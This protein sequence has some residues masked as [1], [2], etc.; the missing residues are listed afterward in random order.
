MPH[1]APEPNLHTPLT[2]QVPGIN[3][4]VYSTDGEAVATGDVRMNVSVHRG[5]AVVMERNLGSESDKVRP[6]ERIRGLEFSGDGRLLFVAAADT[7]YALDAATGATVWSYEP[8]RSFGFLIISPIALTAMGGLV[9]ASFDNGSVAVWDEAGTLRCLW[10]D[11]D[12]PRHFAL[13]YEGSRLIGTDSFTLCVWNATSRSKDTRI[14]L[15]SRAFGFAA[16]RMGRIVAIRTL[17]EIVLWDVEERRSILS[18]PAEP[19]LPVIAFHPSE[20]KFAVAARGNVVVRDFAGVE[21]GRH[22]EPDALVLSMAF[23]PDRNELTL[24]LSTEELRT[25]AL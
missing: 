10:H 20:P 14:P 22:S 18:V 3:H 23:A 5:G 16:S 19:G 25:I 1:L 4:V 13:G 15:P 9:A 2:H 21:L 12:A 6:T 24:G 17:R 8:P 11:N 7:V